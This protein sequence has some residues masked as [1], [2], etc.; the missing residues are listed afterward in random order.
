MT[1]YES[2]IHELAERLQGTDASLTTSIADILTVP[3]QELIEA[4]LTARIGAEPGDGGAGQA[5][6]P[7]VIQ[8]RSAD[9]LIPSEQA[10]LTIG[11]NQ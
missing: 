8:L 11:C 5:L 7:S 2:A 4:E 10:V 1:H 6:D 9:H 3:L